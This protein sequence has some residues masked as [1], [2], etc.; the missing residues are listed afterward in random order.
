MEDLFKYAFG[1]GAF[2]TSL[3]LSYVLFKKFIKSEVV[4]PIKEL[5]KENAELKKN[6]TQFTERVTS[7]IFKILKSHTDLTDSVSRD[8]TTMNQLFS[9]VTSHTS[10][11][12][13]EAFEA[14]KKVNVLETTADKLLKV[15]FALFEKNKKIETEIKKLSDELIFVKTKAGIKNE[16]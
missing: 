10:Q 12:K 2:G 1:G 6:F 13:V 5:E 14:L 3:F 9:E 4:K 8:V 11:S 16:D 15:S 7:F